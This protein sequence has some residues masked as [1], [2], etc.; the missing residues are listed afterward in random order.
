MP[1]DPS[2][3][4]PVPQADEGS[5]PWFDAANEG[6]LLVQRCD[7]CGTHRFPLWE[8][9]SACWSTDW[10]WAE[11]SGRGEI[12]TWARMHHVYHPGFAAEVPYVVAI[13]ELDEGPRVETRLV[14]VAGRELHSGMPVRAVFT[15]MADDV[16]VPLFEPADAGAEASAAIVSKPTSP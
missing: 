9:C 11:T 10:S 1:D 4:I 3:S 8:R 14:N 16:R 15:Q 12:F 2:P 13:V 5:Q 7:A 6:R